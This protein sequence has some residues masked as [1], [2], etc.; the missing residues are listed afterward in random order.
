MNGR[1]VA[2]RAD[3]ETNSVNEEFLALM[4]GLRTTLPGV[5]IITAFLLTLPLQNHFEDLTT[6]ERVAYDVAFAS[7]L[8]SSL[9]LMAPSSHQRLRAQEQ[10]T[11]A[12]RSRH[13]LAVA[14]RLTNVG[15][16]LFAVAMVAVAY[17]ISSVLFDTWV[18]IV[19]TALVAV[20]CAWT[21]FYQPLVA[22][23]RKE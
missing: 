17:L 15:T 12:R 23:V 1:E 5:Q 6:G 7:A 2:A 18:A 20:V 9:L 16:T 22:F 10:G 14:V 19:F 4:E 21:W 8:I 3:H 11:V 13:H